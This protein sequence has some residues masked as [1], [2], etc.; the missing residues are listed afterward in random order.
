MHQFFHCLIRAA[1]PDNG[2]L[3][4]YRVTESRRCQV[5]LFPLLVK[6]Y[7]LTIM[8]NFR[9]IILILCQ[10]FL[11]HFWFEWFSGFS[12][13][14]LFTSDCFLKFVLGFTFGLGCIVQQFFMLCLNDSFLTFHVLYFLVYVLTYMSLSQSLLRLLLTSDTIRSGLWDSIRLFPRI[15]LM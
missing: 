8:R 4:L 6:L 1:K 10:Q 13:F 14:C 2:I 15:N 5:D 11:Q 7:I 12:V 9:W 3:Y